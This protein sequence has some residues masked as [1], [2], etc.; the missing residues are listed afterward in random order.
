[1]YKSLDSTINPG[2]LSHRDTSASPHDIFMQFFM[3]PL[4]AMSPPPKQER[5]RHKQK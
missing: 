4:F 1:M 3:K 2:N 5:N